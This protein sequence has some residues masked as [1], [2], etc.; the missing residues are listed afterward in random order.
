MWARILYCAAILCLF[1]TAAC[2]PL[3]GLRTFFRGNPDANHLHLDV[4]PAQNLTI[5]LDGQVVG[6]GTPLDYD[7]LAS[8]QHKLSIAAMDY[9]SFMVPIDIK[10][11]EPLT[12]RVA[13]RP[14]PPTPQQQRV[15]T[16][17]EPKPRVQQGIPP[18]TPLPTSVPPIQ[19]AIMGEPVGP[20]IVDGD[21][22][23]NKA[24]HIDHV[25]GDFGVG[26]AR[27]GYRVGSGGVLEVRVPED[28]AQ[29]FRDG[30]PMDP[31]ARFAFYRGK[32]R[33]QQIQPNG[34][35]QTIFLAR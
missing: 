21:P 29:W 4:D 9:F 17:R 14:V 13:L 15:T 28:G 12:L 18:P 32:T 27:L 10:E 8:G 34:E 16:P 11:G 24:L 30:E 19:L 35:T 3:K 6:T 23:G 1:G 31:D 5:A 26:R 2:N 7:A 25:T 20:V 22:I 33:L